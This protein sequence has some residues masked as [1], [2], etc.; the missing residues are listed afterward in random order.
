MRAIF[1][2]TTVVSAVAP[3]MCA[4]SGK[5]TIPA[6]DGILMR[7]DS[8]SDS[9]E[10]TTFDLEKGVRL[11]CEAKVLEDGFVILNAQK[12]YA[13]IRA[14]AG[15]EI[16]LIVD[17]Q[18]G[19]T[20]LSGTSSYQMQA[21]RGE[22][23][24]GLPLLEGDRAFTMP[25]GILRTLISQTLFAVAVNEQRAALNGCFFRA[26]E[27]KLL[28]VGCDSFRLARCSAEAEITGDGALDVSFIVPGKTLGELSRML[29]DKTAAGEGETLPAIRI[30]ITRKHVIF[31]FNELVL[32]SRLIDTEY[33]D[34][35]RLLATK[36]HIHAT[37]VRTDLLGALERATLV[38]EEKVVGNVRSWVKL[39]FGGGKIEISSISAT[40]RIYDEVTAELEGE[41]IE[42]GFNN[43]YLIDTLRACDADRIT[44]S[45]STP[46]MMMT[47][48][49]A[50]G[51]ETLTDQLYMVVPV[52][53]RD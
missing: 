45:L 17:S 49:P 27:G 20:V 44:L 40:G 28:L 25:Q 39:S 26:T 22:D 15:D 13:I 24:P 43:R 14:M 35:E 29:D 33:L 42:I 9:V 21:I 38:T 51:E 18:L 36:H 12:F 8:T 52:R 46:M 41:D 48:E 1:N 50:Q 30:E 4:V 23:F 3:L 6:I 5:N 34:Y 31:R 37:L 47:V 16:E 19:A 2:R 32:F 53:M 7:A 10:M 11:S